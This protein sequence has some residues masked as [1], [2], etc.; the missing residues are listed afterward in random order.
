MNPLWKKMQ[1]KD[2]STIL[3]LGAP[4][5]FEAILSDRDPSW[6]VTTGGAIEPVEDAQFDVV[7][8]FLTDETDVAHAAEVIKA[9]V[10]GDDTLLW[11]CY[12]KKS[13]KKYAATISRDTGWDPV[14][15]LGWEGVRQVAVDSD[16]SAL[17][18]RP[19]DAI[20][21]YTRKKKIGK[22]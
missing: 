1:I 2:Q 9:N 15:D 17:R 18:F 4:S 5:E 3:V 10:D 14:I 6:Q 12:P 8:M 22:S 21:S 13:S 19:R 16:W 11:M 20:K 7:I